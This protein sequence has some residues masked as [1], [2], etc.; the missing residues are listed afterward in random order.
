MQRTVPALG[1]LPASRDALEW[2]ID[3]ELVGKTALFHPM[4]EERGHEAG[5]SGAEPRLE[6]RVSRDRDGE[7]CQGWREVGGVSSAGQLRLSGVEDIG[8]FEIDAALP[9]DHSSSKSDSAHDLPE[10]MTTSPPTLHRPP[11]RF[12]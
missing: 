2:R 7:R 6:V 5:R 12:A 11:T 8:Q 10:M 1:S 3:A 9:E 4:G